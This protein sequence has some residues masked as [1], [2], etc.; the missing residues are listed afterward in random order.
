MFLRFL[1]R[2]VGGL[3]HLFLRRFPM[4]LRMLFR[5]LRR[6]FRER[7]GFRRVVVQLRRDLRDFR[8]LLLDVFD[9]RLG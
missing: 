5:D 1:G 9:R 6:F 7:R 4:R 3:P 2:M 8:R